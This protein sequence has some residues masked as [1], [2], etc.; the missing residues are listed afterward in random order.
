MP[1]KKKEEKPKLFTCSLED[2]Y[3]PDIVKQLQDAGIS[4][5]DISKVDPKC[6]DWYDMG[7]LYRKYNSSYYIC[8]GQRGDGKSYSVLRICLENFR[9]NNK[10][11]VYMRRWVD[12][13]NTF[14]CST[15]IK[16]ELV[17]EV[18]GEDYEVNFRNHVFT[19]KHTIIDEETLKESVEKWEIGYAVAVSDSKHR[20]GTNY[21]D[22]NII[23]F[24]EFIDL[25]GENILSNEFNKFENIVNTIKR[26]N[27]VKIFMC[28]NTVSKYSEYL[29][30]LN[31]NADAVEQGSIKE[32][33]SPMGFTYVIYEYCRRNY[34]I[35]YFVGALT[36]SNMIASGEW[37]IPETDEIP[38]CEN[39][40]VEEKL[41]FTA[42]QSDINA[43]IGMYVRHGTWSTYETNDIGLVIPIEHE[44]EFLVIR[45]MPNDSKSSYYHLTN[46]KSLSQTHYHKLDTMLRDIEEEVGIDVKRE[47]EMGRVFCDNMFTGD[48]FTQIWLNYSTVKVRTLL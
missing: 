25:A 33:L 36:Q 45:R 5:D 8:V 15:L 17:N 47:L 46:Q 42:L 11:F 3:N 29:T 37:E 6:I 26:Q 4:P 22:T 44:R 48:I 41:L 43:T 28:A 7:K 31:I 2:N 16:Q 14:A 27:K 30:R 1:R 19:L 21:P 23:F 20:K 40:K 18:F 13:V 10:K 9:D 38:A 32:V 34:L 35:G 39:E 24:D 12:D